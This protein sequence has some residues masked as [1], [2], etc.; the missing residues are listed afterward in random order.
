M[1][2]SRLQALLFF[3]VLAWTCGARAE[4][5]VV[6]PRYDVSAAV[7]AKM[8][9]RQQLAD[10]SREAAESSTFRFSEVVMAKAPYSKFSSAV[11]CLVRDKDGRIV[12]DI[13]ND[14]LTVAIEPTWADGF[15]SS[16]QPAEYSVFS[17]LLRPQFEGRTVTAGYCQRLLLEY[18]KFSS[19]RIDRAAKHYGAGRL[20]FGNLVWFT[21]PDEVLIVFKSSNA[22]EQVARVA[23]G[24]VDGARLH[25]GQPELDH[26]VSAH[27]RAWALATVDEIDCITPWGSIGPPP[28]VRDHAALFPVGWVQYQKDGMDHGVCDLI[29]VSIWR[30]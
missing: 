29:A 2:R 14:N 25:L 28:E 5:T 15:L 4:D 6:L 11:K 30:F 24:R 1:F 13:T 23:G 3:S 12:K 7:I 9:P 26:L 18:V 8:M 17:V 27:G 21:T 19:A 22:C 16:N 20:S 10:I